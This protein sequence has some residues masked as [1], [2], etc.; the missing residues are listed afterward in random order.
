MIARYPDRN[1]LKRRKLSKRMQ[2]RTIL[3]LFAP[4]LIGRYGRSYFCA[5]GDQKKRAIFLDALDAA[6]YVRNLQAWLTRIDIPS[7]D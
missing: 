5:S 1:K 3:M 6:S 2:L 7:S 4:V